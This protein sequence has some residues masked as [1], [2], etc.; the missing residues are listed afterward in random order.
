MNEFCDLNTDM[1]DFFYSLIVISSIEIGN[2]LMSF[3]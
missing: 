3:F 2:K 1:R